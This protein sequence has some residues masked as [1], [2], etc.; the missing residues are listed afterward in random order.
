MNDKAA[1]MNPGGLI[2]LSVPSNRIDPGSKKV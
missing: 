1:G 2:R